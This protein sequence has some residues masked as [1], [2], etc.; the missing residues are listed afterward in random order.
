MSFVEL[1]IHKMSF[2]HREVEGNKPEHC[3]YHDTVL[4]IFQT[5]SF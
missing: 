5:F 1:E 4:L 3:S 2:K